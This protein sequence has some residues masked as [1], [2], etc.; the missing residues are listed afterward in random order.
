M[1]LCK[2]CKHFRG[3]HSR[4][5]FHPR[6]GAWKDY[7]NG[8]DR[9][10]NKSCDDE[11]MAWPWFLRPFMPNT[12]GPEGRYFEPALKVVPTQE[13]APGDKI[14]HLEGQ[15]RIDAIQAGKPDFIVIRE[16]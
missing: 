7:V 16:K 2:D 12:C 8:K 4:R 1:K 9:P 6:F 3:E 15:A 5:C 10:Y 14:L 13:I 11:R